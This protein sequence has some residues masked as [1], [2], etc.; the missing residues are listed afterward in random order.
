M[1]E[2]NRKLLWHLL[3]LTG[4]TVNRLTG[5]TANRLTGTTVNLWI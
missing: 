1:R 4:T 3:L 5:I 2:V